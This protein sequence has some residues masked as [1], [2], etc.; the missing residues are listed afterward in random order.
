MKNPLCRKFTLFYEQN[1]CGFFDLLFIDFL[2]FSFKILPH[3]KLTDSNPHAQSIADP[4]LITSDLRFLA[5]IWSE[6]CI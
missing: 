1:A 6:S 3:S 5:Y 2:F 4:I